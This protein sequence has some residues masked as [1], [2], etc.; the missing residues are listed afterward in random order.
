MLPFLV[1]KILKSS[2]ND[3]R[4]C[5]MK[6]LLYLVNTYMSE[7]NIFDSSI[8]STTTSKITAIINDHLI[9][10]LDYL[11]VHEQQEEAVASMTLKLIAV[12]FQISKVFIHQ[13]CSTCKLTSILKYYNESSS[14]NVLKAIQLLT[15]SGC[16]QEAQFEGIFPITEQILKYYVHSGQEIYLEYPLDILKNLVKVCPQ[17]NI[18]S[19]WEAVVD[20]QSHEDIVIREKAEDL[21]EEFIRNKKISGRGKWEIKS[22]KGL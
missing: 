11:L 6:Y 9:P 21:I 20:L 8:L 2:Q 13:F 19:I 10:Q 16:L 1:G 17:Q 4:F 12:L 3:V 14:V 15:C 5:C 22:K 7:E 18:D